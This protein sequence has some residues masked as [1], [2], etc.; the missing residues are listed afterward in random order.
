MKSLKRTKR[1][2]YLNKKAKY[3]NSIA[4]LVDDQTHVNLYGVVVNFSRTIATFQNLYCMMLLIID[5]G[6]SLKTTEGAIVVFMFSKNIQD[7]PSGL[8]FGTLIKLNNLFVTRRDDY[9][10]GSLSY[11][12]CW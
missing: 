6:H 4:E 9:I 10:H 2:H 5:E 12:S 7:I 3:V 8:K 1:A 11:N